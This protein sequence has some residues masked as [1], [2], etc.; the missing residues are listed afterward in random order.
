MTDSNKSTSAMNDEKQLTSIKRRQEVCG[1][2]TTGFD[3]LRLGLALAVFV[4]HLQSTSVG[5]ELAMETWNSWL[6]VVP[7]A[8]LPMFFALSGFLVSGSLER[9]RTT[10]YFLFLRMIRIF[11]ALAVE[12]WLSALILGPFLTEIALGDY[13]RSADFQAYLLNTIG[14]ISFSLPGVFE[15]NNYAGVVNAQLWTVPWELECYVAIAV[16]SLLKLY[17]SRRIAIL[18][19]L[20]LTA[21]FVLTYIHGDLP[22]RHL[23]GRALVGYFLFGVLFY[24]LR[25]FIPFDPRLF[26]LCL[27]TSVIAGSFHGGGYLIF[28]PLTYVTIYIGLQTWKLPAF[29]HWGDYSYGIFLYHFVVQQTMVASFDWAQS[30]ILNGVASLVATVIL[31]ML[32]WH[33]VELPFQSTRKYGKL[34]E[35]R[36]IAGGLVG[37]RNGSSSSPPKHLVSEVDR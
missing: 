9:C 4:W 3:F 10:G 33:L 31:A 28:L 26:W 27:C 34:M 5:R 32:S 7:T 2:R 14:I 24:R 30:M 16:I 36:W 8:I 20:L 35:S 1:G 23:G 18:L 25:A 6:K 11:P 21:M 19:A 15:A 17:Q 29:M 22:E 13:F 12:V 37:K